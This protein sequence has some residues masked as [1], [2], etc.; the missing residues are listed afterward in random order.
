MRGGGSAG[1]TAGRR[2][3]GNEGIKDQLK[4]WKEAGFREEGKNKGAGRL[5]RMG[6]EGEDSKG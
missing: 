6:V 4:R 3:T 2:S 1:G 5:L